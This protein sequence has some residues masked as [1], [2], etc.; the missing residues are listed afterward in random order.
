MCCAVR[1]APT[2][3]SAM[4]SGASVIA[5]YLWSQFSLNN[6]NALGGVPNPADL[7]RP[8]L[9]ARWAALWKRDCLRFLSCAW[10]LTQYGPVGSE[11]GESTTCLHAD[12]PVGDAMA[13]SFRRSYKPD[14]GVR[15]RTNTKYRLR[16][17]CS[18]T[19]EA[20]ICATLHSWCD[21][22]IE[23]PDQERTS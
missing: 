2:R 21:L 16:L 4:I 12:G 11:I 17:L 18:P 9:R 19:G 8:D 3:N 22:S 14:N 20:P 5:T 7:H 6:A 1:L 15:D 23:V 13:A 10:G